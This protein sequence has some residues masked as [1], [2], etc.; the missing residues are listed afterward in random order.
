[1]KNGK[2]G[3]E[4]D[5]MIPVVFSTFTRGENVN[6]SFF[7]GIGES[8]LFIAAPILASIKHV[9]PINADSSHGRPSKPIIKLPTRSLGDATAPLAYSMRDY[10]SCN[11]LECSSV[12]LEIILRT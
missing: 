11:R 6:A 1:M 2:S 8:P 9:D 3:S 4:S 12:V 10:I 5:E 7:S